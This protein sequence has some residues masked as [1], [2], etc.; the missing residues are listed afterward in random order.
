MCELGWKSVG[1]L[2]LAALPSLD[3]DRWTG[4]VRDADALLVNGGDTKYLC[5]WMRKSGL[6]DLL[7]SLSETTWVG[8][9]AGSMVMTPC[10]GNAFSSTASP[11]TDDSALG[12]VDFSIFPHLDHVDLPEN[13]MA[14]AKR[15]AAGLGGPAYS[16]DDETAI[17]VVDGAVNVIS[18]GQWRMFPA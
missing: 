3:G 13:T 11:E 10:I 15:W 5:K 6:A 16:I 17:Q 4:W 7:P 9:S 8:L 2:E 14:D 12:L 1:I 18:E